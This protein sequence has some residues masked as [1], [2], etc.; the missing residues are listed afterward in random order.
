MFSDYRCVHEHQ[1]Q[2]QYPF[3]VP[4]LIF[5]MSGER[6]NDSKMVNVICKLQ[7]GIAAKRG[8]KK[9]NQKKWVNTIKSHCPIF[10]PCVL[11]GQDGTEQ[12]YVHW[13]NCSQ[14]NSGRRGRR[15]RLRTRTFLCVFSANLISKKSR[16]RFPQASN[17]RKAK[18]LTAADPKNLA[19]IATEE[20]FIH[21]L[22]VNISRS[23]F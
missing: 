4:W 9:K 14:M 17:G 21:F 10:M 13:R 19:N 5:V 6:T 18:V 8:L 11:Y 23:N 3:L 22:R 1:L 20:N 16:L 15:H 2:P 12:L 7:I